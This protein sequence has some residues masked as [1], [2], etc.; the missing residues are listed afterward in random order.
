MYFLLGLLFWSCRCLLHG[1]QMR[2]N[3]RLNTLRIYHLSTPELGMVQ[4][5]EKDDLE[6]EVKWNVVLQKGKYGLEN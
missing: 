4:P 2:H 3:K 1:I 5:N 6:N